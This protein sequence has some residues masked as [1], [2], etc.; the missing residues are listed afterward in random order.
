MI[1]AFKTTVGVLWGFGASLFAVSFA[2]LMLHVVI[3][4][5]FTVYRLMHS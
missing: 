1:N 5:A 3:I 4:A 2:I